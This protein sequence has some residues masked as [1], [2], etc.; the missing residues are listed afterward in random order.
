MKKLIALILLTTSYQ[1]L[2]TTIAFAD[3]M[4][5]TKIQNIAVTA[6]VLP[7]PGNYQ[8]SLVQQDGG[9]SVN[10]GKYYAYTITYGA[11]QITRIDTPNTVITFDWSQALAPNG[12]IM[13][14]YVYG[15]ASNAYGDAK[16]VVDTGNKTITWTIPNLPPGTTDQTLVFQLFTDSYDNATNFPLYLTAKMTND[17][18]TMPDQ[19]LTTYY[20]FRPAPPGPTATPAPPQ[21]A[22]T[23]PTPAPKPP[24]YSVD[25]TNITNSSATIYTTTTYP[26]QMTIN[27]GTSPGNLSQ[28]VSN[29][30]F[31]TENT[32][33][34]TNLK[35]DTPYY[36]SLTFR[37][38]N[39]HTNTTET[40]TF[41]TATQALS[42]LPLNGT[43]VVSSGGSVLLSEILANNMSAGFALLT[44]SFPYD[45]TITP[46]Q[47]A[48]IK[49]MELL[50]GQ[51]QP[52]TTVE[53]SRQQNSIYTAHMSSLSRG[54]YTIWVKTLD[55]IGTLTEQKIAMLKVIS[56]LT[57]TNQQSG[58][59]IGN[60]RIFLSYFDQGSNSY[61]PMYAG[62]FGIQSNP[63]YTDGNG[64]YAINL[65]PGKYR[66]QASALFYDSATVDFTLGKEDGETFPH[67]ALKK[68]PFN[69]IALFMVFKDYIIDLFGSLFATLHTIATSSRVFQVVATTA[70]GSL[71]LLGYLLFL[72]KSH[73]SLKYLPLFF[74]IHLDVLRAKHKGKYLFGKVTD[75]NGMPLSLVRVEVEDADTKTILRHTTTNKTGKFYFLNKFTN[76]VNLIFVKEGFQPATF[77]STGGFPEEGLQIKLETGMPHHFS[78]ITLLGRGFRD[79]MGMFL[80]LHLS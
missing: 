56:P 69:F 49:S 11:Q 16:P 79:I 30:S 54:T 51:D 22:V 50:V 46:P 55:E 25:I 12:Q 47:Q 39:G 71:I 29:N 31:Q 72:L 10:N 34:L 68:D 17:Y 48:N 61:K 78:A 20:Q 41:R 18:V 19:T 74:F 1:L 77:S 35:P 67:I 44:S 9:N 38:K 6:N 57:V 5:Q 23:T 7:E 63:G 75:T 66:A 36:F 3:D 60:S 40:Y 73:T 15:S 45:V 21:P 4:G 62:M 42:A 64:I 43:A 76:P 52:D 2:P 80:K 58:K 8:L 37:Y 53:M 28:S 59:P 14:D 24:A 27:Y 26:T 13:F 32:T 33:T 65:P 70:T